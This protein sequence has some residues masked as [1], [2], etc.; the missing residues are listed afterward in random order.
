[1]DYKPSG[2][3]CDTVESM[4][5][6]ESRTEYVLAQFSVVLQIEVL[7]IL[8]IVWVFVVVVTRNIEIYC[9]FSCYTG[10]LIKID[11]SLIVEQSAKICRRRKQD[12]AIASSCLI[13]VTPLSQSLPVP[14]S[15]PY[16]SP[17]SF[18][19]LSP[20]SPTF[21]LPL[22]RVVRGSS[23]GKLWNSRLLWVAAGEF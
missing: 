20:P 11:V 15:L 21:P 4:D 7:A 10:I 12:E 17:P 8:Q 13:L 19:S 1:M 3:I 14:P 6:I 23:P 2:E 18:T 9:I 5:D 16:P 22:K